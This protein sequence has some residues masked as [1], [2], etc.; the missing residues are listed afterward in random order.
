M[1]SKKPLQICVDAWK[2]VASA[3]VPYATTRG[4]ALAVGVMSGFA[5]PRGIDPY[6][7]GG[8]LFKAACTV[9]LCAA[10]NLLFYRTDGRAAVA[11]LPG[12][13]RR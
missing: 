4:A 12:C 13:I 1:A 10:F 9:G 6:H 11:G 8:T 5:S 3:R 7:H 2:I